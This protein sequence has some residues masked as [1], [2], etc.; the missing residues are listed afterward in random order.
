MNYFSSNLKYLREMHKME[1]IELAHKLGRKSSSSVSEW[2]KGKYTPKSGVLSDIANIFNISLSE[3]MQKDLTDNKVVDI[4]EHSQL[5]T[6]YR[7]FPCSVSAGAPL[8][9][10]C[11]G[12]CK[13]ITIPDE[14]LGKY[15]GSKE[16]FF[17]RVNG[18]SMN[19]LFPH[20]SLIAV[21]EIEQSELKNG[22]IVVYSDSYNYAVKRFYNI[23]NKL[24]FKPES[25]DPTFTDYIVD[26]TNEELRLHGKVVTYIVNLN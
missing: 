9:I 25:T 11:I 23:G 26:T 8:E 2:E 17:M 5:S 15:A 6:E 12:N 24:I 4:I 19:R 3:L 21:K 10:E 16:I 7:Y 14:L 22:D 18:E 1:Q 20:D 13:T